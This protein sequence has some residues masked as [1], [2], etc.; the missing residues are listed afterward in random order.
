MS[1]NFDVQIDRKNTASFKWDWCNQI[2]GTNDLLPMS[3]ADMDIP[4]PPQ[5]V[6]AIKKRADHPVFGYTIRMDSFYESVANWMNKRFN[7][8][9]KK[10]WIVSTPGIVPALSFA[11]FSYTQPG[12]KILI[13]P[14]VY[15]PFF[16]AIACNGRFLVENPLK[17]IH[18]ENEPGKIYYEIDFDDLENKL[19]DVKMMILCSPHNPVGRVWSKSDLERIGKLCKEKGVLI[20]SDEI[21]ADLIYRPNTQIPFGSLSDFN[22][23]SLT[24]MAP[25]KTFNVAGLCASVIIIPNDNLREKYSQ[26]MWSCGINLGNTF[27]NVVLETCYN[28]CEEWLDN[29]MIYL[30]ECRQMIKD[31]IS[32]ELPML[33]IAQSE[34]T[35]LTWIDFRALNFKSHEELEQFMINEAKIGMDTG[36]KFGAQGEGFMRLNFGCSKNTIMEALNRLKTAINNR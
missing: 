29:L 30:D 18:Y 21:H 26:T 9:I 10:E 1:F 33:K 12:D 16:D 8:D 6:E 23:I 11:V 31:F 25:S 27:G 15:H 28:E 35:F 36:S 3:I 4:V 19:N 5:V 2:F 32:N 17:E 24:C 13:Q 34:A 20:I 7:W 14:P 22:D